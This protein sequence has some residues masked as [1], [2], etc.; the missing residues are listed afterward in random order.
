[1]RAILKQVEL[2]PAEERRWLAEKL[3]ETDHAPIPP[4]PTGP[5]PLEQRG[6]LSSLIGIA[7][8]TGKQY[9]DGDIDRIRTEAMVAKHSKHLPR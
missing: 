5:T 1:M 3:A 9:S 6:S 4:G 2:W 7:N 8:P